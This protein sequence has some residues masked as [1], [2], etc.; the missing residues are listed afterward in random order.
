MAQLSSW[1]ADS[2][3]ARPDLVSKLNVRRGCYALAYVSP[4]LGLAIMGYETKDW[5]VCIAIMTVGKQPSVLSKLV[6]VTG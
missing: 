5:V 2:L 1:I 3:V 4:A 6:F